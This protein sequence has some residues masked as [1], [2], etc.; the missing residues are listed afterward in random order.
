MV[1]ESAQSITFS[2][3]SRDGEQDFPGNMTAK[4]TYTLD[5]NGEVAIAYEAVSYTH[6]A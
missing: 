6:L 3:V 4:V 5:D 2:Y 1:Q